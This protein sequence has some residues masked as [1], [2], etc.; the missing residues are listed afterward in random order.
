MPADF[1]DAIHGLVYRGRSEAVPK[2]QKASTRRKLS[3][4]TGSPCA[5]KGEVLGL[6]SDEIGLH[7]ALW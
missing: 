2:P 1:D 6:G 4:E 3:F 5:W 7:R